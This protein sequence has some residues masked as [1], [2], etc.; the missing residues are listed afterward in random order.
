MKK[1]NF[2]LRLQ[3]SL[4]EEARKVA[5]AEGVAINQLINVAVAEKVSALRTAMCARR[6]ESSNEQAPGRRRSPAMNSRRRKRLGEGD[7]TD[8]ADQARR[9]SWSLAPS[10]F[11]A[12]LRSRARPSLMASI[13]ARSS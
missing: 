2:A 4:M 5:K 6:F 7:A 12:S 11:S 3:P 1:S 9:S 8:S 10:A 13:S